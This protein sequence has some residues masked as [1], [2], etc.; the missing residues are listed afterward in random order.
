M[1]VSF[2]ASSVTTSPQVSPVPA[3]VVKIANPQNFVATGDVTWLLFDGGMRKGY[4]EQAQGAVEAAQ[5][6]ARRTGL[7]ITDSVVRMCWGALLARELRQL[8]DDTLARLPAALAAGDIGPP[9]RVALSE[10]LVATDVNLN[11]ARV[12][13]RFWIDRVRLEV[14]RSQ[15][16]AAGMNDFVAKPV[17]LETVRHAL[18]RWSPPVPVPSG[19]LH[20]PVAP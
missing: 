15:C 5:A 17:S 7:E 16:L 1:P 4:R 14:I 20:A 8:G 18:E 6:E 2:P 11:D 9:V 12:A 3:Q 13:T 19:A 10:N